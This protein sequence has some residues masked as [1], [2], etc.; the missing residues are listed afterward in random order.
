MTH[1]SCIILFKDKRVYKYHLVC[2]F[3][4]KIHTSECVFIEKFTSIVINQ[5]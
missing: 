3:S 1:L 4:N 2:G 5:K